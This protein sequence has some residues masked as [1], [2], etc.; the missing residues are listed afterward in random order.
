MPVDNV[1]VG[2]LLGVGVGVGSVD[3]EGVGVEVG[4]D[5][6]VT[7]GVALFVG[8]GVTTTVLQLL[9]S[10][11]GVQV[12]LINLPFR[13]DT[14]SVYTFTLIEWLPADIGCAAPTPTHSQLLAFR[15]LTDCEKQVVPSIS[16]DTFA[17][18]FPLSCSQGL[19]ESASAAATVI[20]ALAEP[21]SPVAQ[22][23]ACAR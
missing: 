20:D 23:A 17:V 21:I 13:S 19:Y 3:C 9:P 2:E 4:V 16:T 15:P 6:C 11:A 7:V 5:D 10:P 22:P 14:P 18:P 8:V 12:S 1:A